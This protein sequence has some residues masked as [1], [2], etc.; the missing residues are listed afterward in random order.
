MKAIYKLPIFLVV[1]PLTLVLIFNFPFVPTGTYTVCVRAD[2]SSHV[3]YDSL[4]Q[5]YF[6]CNVFSCTG[7]S[8]VE[9]ITVEYA[10]LSSGTG[11]TLRS[12]RTANLTIV[13]YNPDQSTSI[14]SISFVTPANAS[15]TV[16]QC[17][18]S[19][20]CDVISS[21]LI[22]SGK[23]T[24]F[25]TTESAFY[26]SGPVVAGQTYSYAVSFTDGQSISGALDAQ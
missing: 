10:T 12:R 21:P 7:G 22:P 17:S 23:I 4:M 15:L 26:F 5:E 14:S 1:V 9:T 24:A 8:N 25:N 2:C 11:S 16:Y 18:S 19:A 3:V 6:P 20:S 13:F